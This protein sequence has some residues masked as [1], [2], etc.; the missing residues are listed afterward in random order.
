MH[1]YRR[2]VLIALGMILLG[3]LLWLYL[4]WPSI[5]GGGG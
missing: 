5:A 4:A 1:E 2:K 3:A